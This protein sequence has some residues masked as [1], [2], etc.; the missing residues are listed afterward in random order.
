[1][2][3]AGG[4]GNAGRRLNGLP[5][6][7]PFSAACERNRGPILEVLRDHWRDRRSV[8]EVGSGTGQH[9][10]HFGAALPHLQ[11]QTADRTEYLA[12]IR[13]WLAEAALP[14]VLEPL[15]LDVD[16]PA[17][18]LGPFDAAFSANTL[19]IMSWPQVQRLFLQ[20]RAV[21]ATD[22]SVVIYGPFNYDCRFTSHSNAQFDASLRQRAAHMGIRDFGAVDALAR[23]IGLRLVEDREMPANNR[24]VVWR[25]AVTSPV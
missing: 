21:L 23:S 12:G 22:A 10:V 14:N 20:L 13:A 16:Q 3:L 4:V 11:W 24:C 1:M 9:A 6:D 15:E 19:H 7:K 18:S 5:L 8:L 25:R 2:H 17:W